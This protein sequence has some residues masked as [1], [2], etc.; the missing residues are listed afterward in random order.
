MATGAFCLTGGG[1]VGSRGGGGEATAVNVEDEDER[2]DEEGEAIERPET[3]ED[4]LRTRD[5]FNTVFFF[6]FSF[7]LLVGLV[8]EQVCASGLVDDVEGGGLDDDVEGGGLD[9]EGRGMG[10]DG[11]TLE[12]RTGKKV[13]EILIQKQVN[14]AHVI[15]EKRAY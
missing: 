1:G 3:E 6:P 9:L 2:V 14:Y 8:F 4:L 7:F 13:R 10:F 15:K 5:V 12:S 11:R